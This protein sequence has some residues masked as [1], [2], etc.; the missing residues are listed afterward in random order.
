MSGFGVGFVFLCLEIR[1]RYTNRT[2]A[3]GKSPCIGILAG[4]ACSYKCLS[5]WLTYELLSVYP[6]LCLGAKTATV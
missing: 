3:L 5:E 2:N 1:N 4:I 6:N